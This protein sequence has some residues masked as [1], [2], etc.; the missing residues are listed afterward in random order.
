MKIKI[1]MN[2]KGGII[3]LSVIIATVLIDFITKVIVMNTMDLQ[4]SIPLI[5]NVLH[6]TY[7]TNDGAAFGSF[8]EQRWVFMSISTVMILFMAVLLFLWTDRDPLFYA[9]VSMI[10]GGGIG[11]MIDRIAYGTVVDFI[12]FCA[13]PN[14]WM[15]I[16]N[17]ADAF[18]CVGVGL[19][20]IYYVRSEIKASKAKKEEE[21]TDSES[22]L[23]SEDGE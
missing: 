6:L 16:F 2:R 23:F 20:I 12:D 3:S 10:V 13:F 4:Q 9:S 7:I 5:N 17:G 14:L 21:K 11:N 18:V 8:S 19:F 1:A 15:W 22:T